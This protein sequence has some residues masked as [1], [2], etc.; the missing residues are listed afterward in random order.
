[1]TDVS[2]FNI[3]SNQQLLLEKTALFVFTA[4]PTTTWIVTSYLM[5]C[6]QRVFHFVRANSLGHFPYSVFHLRVMLPVS[7]QPDTKSYGGG[8]GVDR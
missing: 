4:A 1:M 8:T 5:S 6:L 2:F 7:L 3:F